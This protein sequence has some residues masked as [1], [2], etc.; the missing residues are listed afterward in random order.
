MLHMPRHRISQLSQLSA[1]NARF[2]LSGGWQRI[3]VTAEE[4]SIRV[5][6]EATVPRREAWEN[7]AIVR[8]QVS[9]TIEWA[10][11][12]SGEEIDRECQRWALAE[13]A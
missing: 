5:V 2:W 10:Q 7:L 3:A 6:S 13:P 1:L 9:G 12:R 8:E 11:G 4:G